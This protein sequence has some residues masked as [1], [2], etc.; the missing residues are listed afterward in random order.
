M[1]CS[2]RVECFMFSAHK[3]KHSNGN[4]SIAFWNDC[5][6]IYYKTVEASENRKYKSGK[7]KCSDC[8]CVHVRM[9]LPGNMFQFVENRHGCKSINHNHV[10][11]KKNACDV[12]NRLSP[13]LYIVCA[14]IFHIIQRCA[15]VLFYTEISFGHY[16]AR[17]IDF[18]SHSPVAFGI[19][20]M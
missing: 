9:H 16:M 7:Y 5:T 13:V 8:E 17:K 12:V 18:F 6:T 2:V 1:E 15:V 3:L 10:F 11:D 4:I 14:L 19:H 20:V